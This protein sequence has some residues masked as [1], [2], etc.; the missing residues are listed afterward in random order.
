MTKEK[1]IQYSNHNKLFINKC[2]YWPYFNTKAIWLRN[3]GDTESVMCNVIKMRLN[4]RTR[5]EVG[6]ETLKKGM[7]LYIFL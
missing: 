4:G 5:R 1:V 2:M 3:F 7:N 6:K